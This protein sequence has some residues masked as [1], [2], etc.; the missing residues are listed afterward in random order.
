MPNIQDCLKEISTAVKGK[1]V[2]QSIH[3]GIQQCYYDG[4]A[5]AIDLEARQMMNTKADKTELEV[6]RQRITN[7]STLPS[8]STTGD[9]ELQDIRIGYDGKNYANAGEAVR[10]QVSQLSND[11]N[12]VLAKES[13]NCI[14]VWRQGSIDGANGTEFYTTSHIRSD[15]VRLTPN[16]DTY[17]AM[18]KDKGFYFVIGY[19]E[20]KNYVSTQ[21]YDGSYDGEKIKVKTDY[22]YIRIVGANL[23]NTDITPDFGFNIT[24]YEHSAYV[25]LMNEINKSDVY[26]TFGLIGDSISTFRGYSELGGEYYP[27]GDIT[28]VEQTYWKKLQKKLGFTS[29]PIISAISSTSYIYNDNNNL[30][31]SYNDDRISRVCDSK[32]QYIFINMGTNDPFFESIGETPTIYNVDKLE[33][34]ANSTAKGIALT[35]RK[36]QVA[37][38]NSKIVLL[39]P[40]FSIMASDAYTFKKFELVCKKLI[41]IGNMYGVYKI[42]D[43]RKC[44]INYSNVYSYT[45]DGAHPNVSGMELIAQYI[46]NEMKK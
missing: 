18:P 24:M 32:P 8:G 40:K 39:V 23:Y 16:V 46:A 31:C 6:E 11:M 4:K 20:L 28:N 33:E 30:P 25:K 43:L 21:W 38:P 44:G 29:E 22:K 13:V 9:A 12:H 17:V 5:G 19:D 35:I 7:L 36:I 10:G 34:L 1:D 37:S 14:L 27:L 3:D 41:E 26:T 45:Q 15:Y 2:R 42:I